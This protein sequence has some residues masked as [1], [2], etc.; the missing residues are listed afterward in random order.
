MSAEL[1]E[2]QTTSSKAERESIA[3]RDGIKGMKDQ[4]SKEVKALKGEIKVGVEE[5]KRGLEET[6]STLFPFKKGPSP[7]L[8]DTG[9]RGAQGF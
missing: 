9:T 4:W 2:A 6:V 5:G 3:L 1:I 8:R 7:E